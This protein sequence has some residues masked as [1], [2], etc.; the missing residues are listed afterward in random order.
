MKHCGKQITTGD[1]LVV[2]FREVPGEPDNCL[3]VKTRSLSE[4]DHDSL[5]SVLEGLEGQQA[6]QLADVLHHHMNASGRPILD[7]LHRDRKMLKLPTTDVALT[8]D[9]INAVPLN[10]VNAAIKANE[11]DHTHAKA[12]EEMA[13]SDEQLAKSLQSQADTLEAEVTRLREEA[14]G[15]EPKKKS[16]NGRKKAKKKASRTRATA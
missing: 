11:L 9:A 14:G 5:M 7:A 16:T 1:K 13:L 4:S 2:V 12:A 3:V 8:P 10:E 15:L 6:S